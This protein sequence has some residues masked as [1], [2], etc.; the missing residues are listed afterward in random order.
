VNWS[1]YARSSASLVI[2]M[3]LHNLA[4]IVRE[5]LAHG[6]DPQCP[7]AIVE[8]GTLDTQRTLVGPL[9]KIADLAKDRGIRPPALIVVGEVVRLHDTLDWFAPAACEHAPDAERAEPV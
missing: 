7:V 3:G 5:L 8:N 4:S 2:F 6:R 9:A 1:Q